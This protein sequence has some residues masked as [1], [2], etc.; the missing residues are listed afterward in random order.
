MKIVN[1]HHDHNARTNDTQLPILYD[2]IASIDKAV[3][4]DDVRIHCPH[5][6]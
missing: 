5:L 3:Y 6:I 4:S 1:V 2:P